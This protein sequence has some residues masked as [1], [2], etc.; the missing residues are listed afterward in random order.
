MCLVI[1]RDGTEEGKRNAEAELL[2]YA[3]ELDR[4]VRLAGSR[5]DPADTPVEEG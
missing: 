4:L 3:K 5:F 1:L 2:R